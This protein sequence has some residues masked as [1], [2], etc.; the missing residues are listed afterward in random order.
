ME[1]ERKTSRELPAYM[2]SDQY[3]NTRRYS[4]PRVGPVIGMT[5]GPVDAATADALAR[6]AG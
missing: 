3:L 2:T 6:F 4:E 1:R 5:F